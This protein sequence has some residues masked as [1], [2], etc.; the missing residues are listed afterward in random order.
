MAQGSIPVTEYF[1]SLLDKGD[2]KFSRIRELPNFGRARNNADF[3]K[4]FKIYTQLWKLQQEHRQ[5]L[6]EAGLKRWEIGEIASR[7]AQLY[8]FQ[9]QRTSDSGNLAESYVFYEAILTREYFRDSAA[10]AAGA[11]PMPPDPPLANKQLRFFARFLIVCLVLGRRDMV[12]QLANHLRMLVDESRRSFQE[13]EYKEWKHVVQEIFRFLKLDTSFMNMRPLRYSFVYD[14][15]P[16]S[17]PA[18][19]YNSRKQL[20]LRDAILSSYCHNEVKFAELT[21]DT[22]RMLQCLEWEPCGSFSLNIATTDSGNTGGGP[23][24]MNLQQD[25]RDSALPPNPQKVILY[26]PSITSFLLVLATIC[27]ELPSDGILLI[28]LSASGETGE[29]YPMLLS[30]GC[31]FDSDNQRGSSKD[32]SKASPPVS[33]INVPSDTFSEQMES[34]NDKQEAFLW[35]GS[36]RIKG[37]KLYPC[38]LIPFT[39]KPLFLIIDS[40]SSHA[41]KVIHGDEKGETMAMLLSPKSQAPAMG[42]T[43]ESPRNQNISQFTLFLTAPVQAF[44]I[45][46]GVSGVNLEMETYNDAEELLLSS[47][48][49]WENALLAC[50]ELHP[51][52]I[53]VLGDPFL[54]RLLLRFIFCRS[55]LAL[56]SL[57]FQ[58]EEYF[59]SCLP[60]LPDCLR[61]GSA[62]SESAVFALANFFGVNGHFVF[63]K[64]A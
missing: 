30:P 55:V 29:N 33:P 16:Y 12:S 53:G 50:G 13:I 49:E 23:N 43:S 41:F 6:V 45:L 18:A 31:S 3:Q 56:Y 4:A 27:E 15:H 36:R 35:L 57:T 28:Y 7:I 26:R 1:W 48:Y 39:R 63:S 54:R 17:L 60:N 25:I 24:R 2:R 14:M 22:F 5:K 59:P 11:P 44:C 20:V 52:W 46:L 37:S 32:A 10:A 42:A 40:N 38:D 51:I 47:L 19:S 21:L 64:G 9:Y 8:Y 62:L 58:Q 34:E 61:P